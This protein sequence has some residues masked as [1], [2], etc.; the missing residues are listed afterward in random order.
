MKSLLRQLMSCNILKPIVCDKLMESLDKFLS[1]ELVLHQEKFVNY[2]REKQRLD[3]FYFNSVMDMK[4]YPKFSLLLKLV[5]VLSHGQAAVERGFNLHDIS[6]QE[7]IGAESTNSR[8]IIIDHMLSLGLTPETIDIPRKLLLSVKSARFR[9][10]EAKKEQRDKAERETKHQKLLNIDN[11]ITELKGK[12]D[13]LMKVN[14][15]LD[16]EFEDLIFKADKSPDV[17][18]LLV[19]KSTAMKRKS[20]QNKCDVKKLEDTLEVLREKR[21]KLIH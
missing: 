2:K 16:K 3:D 6:L 18:Q 15:E 20:N 19:S 13:S 10:E 9:Y 1:S 17:A 4:K 11:D 21:K 12:I 14:N 5:F 8:R 7:N